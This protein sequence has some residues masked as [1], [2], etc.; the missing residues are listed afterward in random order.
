LAP[1]SR[2]SRA[3]LDWLA[4]S[5]LCRIADRDRHEVHALTGFSW[6]F[7]I[8]AETTMPVPPHSLDPAAWNQ[9]LGLLHARHPAWRFADGFRNT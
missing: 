2:D 1:P 3:D 7:T 6:G 9:H 4:H 5:F 8:T